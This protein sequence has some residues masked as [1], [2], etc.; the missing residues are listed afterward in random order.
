MSL[1]TLEFA[2]SSWFYGLSIILAQPFR[3]DFSKHHTSVAMS[4]SEAAPQTD[5]KGS[6]RQPMQ[7]WDNFPIYI[8][9]TVWRKFI[10]SQNS[11]SALD[12]LLTCLHRYGLRHPSE[13]TQTILVAVLVLRE[14]D[15]SK[16]ERMRESTHLRAL[17]CN[18]KSQ[19]RAKFTKLLPHATS[20]PGGYLEVLPANPE[21]APAEL[22]SLCFQKN[23]MMEDQ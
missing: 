21:D 2:E 19:L 12:L 20:P 7:Q 8:S 16:R 5:N 11:I 14:Q 9:K 10:T 22:K 15:M 17:F 18:V 13:P 4:S 23:Q 3:R 1:K 6:K